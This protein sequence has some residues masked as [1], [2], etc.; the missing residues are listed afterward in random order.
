MGEKFR[1]EGVGVS[2]GNGVNVDV[3]IGNGVEVDVNSTVGA[4]DDA[5]QALISIAA[6][7]KRKKWNVFT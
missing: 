7:T 5:P 4:E 6:Y 2:V 3:E 1:G